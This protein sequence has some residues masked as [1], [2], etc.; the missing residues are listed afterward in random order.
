M[1]QLKFLL[2]RKKGMTQIFREDGT[3]VPVTIVDETNVEPYRA[4]FK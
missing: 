2:A 3:V 4:I 1:S